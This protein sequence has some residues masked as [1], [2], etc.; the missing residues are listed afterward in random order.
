MQNLQILLLI[1]SILGISEL[2]SISARTY[3]FSGGPSG[4]VYQYFASGVSTLAKKA[5]INLLASA[6]G[7]AIEN[8]RLVNAEKADFGI[9]NSGDVYSAR[10]GQLIG[11][12][13][14][15]ENI[16]AINFFYSAVAQLVVRAEDRI[17][18]VKQLE[19]K[20][21]A[22]GNPGSGAAA[23]AEI[24]FKEIGIWE[25]INKE[26]LGYREA[27][28]AFKNRQLDAFWVFAGYPNAAITE[29]A[30][31]N[32]IQLVDVYTEA[33]KAGMFKKYPYLTKEV[34]PA[35][36][37]SGQTQEVAT[38]SDAVIFFAHKN[39]P[40]EVV[41]NLLKVLY[42]KEGLEYMVSVHKAAQEMKIEHGLKGIVTPLHPGA[43]KFWKEMKVLK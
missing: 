30:L 37:Y 10:M 38:Y 14:K 33:E 21:V 6:S 20:R 39:V 2:F 32:K 41:Y 13:K 5:N 25:K 28:E 36:T 4:G 3:R 24:F 26:F 12:S 16:F 27:A 29:A 19:G 22:V 43:E 7:G 42:S 18:S 35:N 23:A 17:T 34:L 1:I 8:I 11:D 9:A 40:T 15:Y 31:Q